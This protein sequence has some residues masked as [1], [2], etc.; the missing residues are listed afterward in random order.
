VQPERQ[1]QSRLGRRAS[2]ALMPAHSGTRSSPGANAHTSRADAPRV[3][4]GPGSA[5]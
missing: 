1:Q 3:P 4:A 2:T 5:P